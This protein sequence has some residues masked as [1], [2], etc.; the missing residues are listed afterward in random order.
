MTALDACSVIIGDHDMGE[1]MF[2]DLGLYSSLG[3]SV[4]FLLPAS[5]YFLTIH[6]L[7]ESQ[8]IQAQLPRISHRRNKPPPQKQFQP[9]RC[10]CGLEHFPALNSD[11]EGFDE[12]SRERY[13]ATH[14]SAQ[15]STSDPRRY[16]PSNDHPPSPEQHRTPQDGIYGPRPL[17]TLAHTT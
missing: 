12:M 8:Q 16:D 10:D 4:S 1:S 2:N 17:R 11:H 13:Q 3:T 14:N 6:I 15:S 5:C 7:L 9:H